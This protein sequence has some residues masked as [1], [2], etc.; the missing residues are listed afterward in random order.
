M[1]EHLVWKDTFKR[2]CPESLKCYLYDFEQSHFYSK[3][4]VLRCKYIQ[5]V[6]NIHSAYAFDYEY[7]YM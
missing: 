6:N 7:A 5:W 4:Q 1:L 2:E 3:I